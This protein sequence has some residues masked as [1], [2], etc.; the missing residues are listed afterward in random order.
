[1]NLTGYLAPEGLEDSLKS[2][3]KNIAA[4]YGRL[5]LAEGPPQN[6][7][8]VQ[9]VW[10]NPQTYKFKSLSDAAKYLRSL[11]KLWAFYPYSQTGKGKLIASQ[12]AYFSPKPLPFPSPLPKTPLGS[13]MLLDEETLLASP[14]CS[15]PFAHGEVHFQ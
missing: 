3:L 6:V 8:W 5:F 1:M 7:H 2:E 11:Q 13:W 9:N 14:L 10:H 15:S 4:Q 12:L